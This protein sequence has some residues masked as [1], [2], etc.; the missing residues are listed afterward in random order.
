MPASSI[1]PGRPS[2]PDAFGVRSRPVHGPLSTLLVLAL[3][4]APACRPE[5]VSTPPTDPAHGSDYV[6]SPTEPTTTPVPA[7]AEAAPANDPTPRILAADVGGEHDELV[8]G[9]RVRAEYGPADP[10]LG[11]MQPTVTIV[12]FLDYQC[13]YSKK[14]VPTLYELA[15][16]YPDDLRVVVKH[17][18]LPM[19]KDARLAAMA[20]IAAQRQGRFWVMH[21]ALFENQ[22]DLEPQAVLGHAGRLGFDLAQLEDALQDASVAAQVDADIA[23]AKRLGMRG[24]PAMFINGRH[25]TGARALPE[26]RE[27]VQAELATAQRLLDAGAPRP[28]LYAHF[29]HAAKDEAAAAPP[30]RPRSEA[31]ADDVRREVDVTG[32]PRKGPADPKVT[33]VECSDFDCPFCA[34]VGPTLDALLA[35]H[36]DDVAL[37][38]RHLPLAFHQGA[39]PAARAAVAA[40]AQGKFWPMH[41]LLFKNQGERSDAELEKL[42]RKAGVNVKK[43]RKA[44]RSPATAA[45]VKT[46]IETCGANGIHGTPGFLVNGRLLSGARPLEDFEQVVQEELARTR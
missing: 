8:E 17:N 20:A 38:Y 40:Q 36:P 16:L 24:T 29:M 43:W 1:L 44:F 9:T 5:P 25:V 3:T 10:W 14:L 30:T 4:F 45:R 18:P 15:A 28:A 46:E 19:H 11:A 42:A 41:D 12:A 27:E 22:K 32:L 35:N 37:F 6:A 39:E 7:A 21:D 31:I 13:P 26:L 33:I 34:R 23:Q 2:Q